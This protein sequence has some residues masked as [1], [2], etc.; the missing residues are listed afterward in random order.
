M[1]GLSFGFPRLGAKSVDMAE[2]QFKLWRKPTPVGKAD[3]RARAEIVRAI[4]HAM[5][6]ACKPGRFLPR[7]DGQLR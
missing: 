4:T 7:Q 3:A 2:I 6:I 5:L 1:P